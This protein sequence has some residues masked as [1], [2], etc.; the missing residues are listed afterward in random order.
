MAEL[1]LRQPAADLKSV[2]ATLA[3]LSIGPIARTAAAARIVADG[4]V[5][6]EWSEA[7]KSPE[8][9][10]GFLDAIPLVP[11]AAL[12]GSAYERVKGLLVSSR[13]GWMTS[14]KNGTAYPRGSSTLNCREKARS[15]S[16]KSR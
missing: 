5:E 3:K 15:R 12:R 10:A 4:S 9:L 14:S 6:P 11:D 7:R 16:R 2:R 1:L 8:A 13:T